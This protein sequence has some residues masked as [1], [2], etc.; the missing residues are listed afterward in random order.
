MA[1]LRRNDPCLCGS[2]KKYKKCCL[3][4][5]EAKPR[6]DEPDQRVFNEL[7]PRIF[8][9]SKR[10]D[11]EIEPVYAKLAEQFEG[12]Q[13][14]DG[15]AFSQLIFHWILFNKPIASGGETILSDYTENYRKD[16]SEKFQEFL[17]EWEAMQPEFFRVTYA[18][19]KN[20]AL[21]NTFSGEAHTLEK[22]PASANL[23][24][25]D[26]VIGYLY[27][28]PDGKALG[29][30]ALAIPKRIAESFCEAWDGIKKHAS[31]DGET[32][33]E[34]FTRS[35]PDVLEVLSV[36]VSAQ[37]VLNQE[38][39]LKE[40][41]KKVLALI[42]SELDWTRVPY[43][44]YLKA[45]IHWIRFVRTKEPRIQKPETF[46]AALEYWTDKHVTDGTAALSQKAAAEKYGVSPSTVSSKYK[47]LTQV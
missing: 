2:G 34:L 41:G 47:E 17:Q 46:A 4:K 19:E 28:T 29:N 3:N 44:G 45:K 15:E 38:D 23:K 39:E 5:V 22:T 16:Y 8:D 18:D 35:F 25:N 20:M 37:G 30:D 31:L 21:E 26:S 9:H 24:E 1:T 42:H 33:Q 13:K 27:P 7:L 40:S 14:R 43:T 11:D 36:L 12:M 32:D 10:F 6:F